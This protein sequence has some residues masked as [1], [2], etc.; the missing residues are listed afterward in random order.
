MRVDGKGGS[1]YQVADN[2]LAFSSSG[3]SGADDSSS[4]GGSSRLATGVLGSGGVL[5]D[6]SSRDSGLITTARTTGVVAASAG[7]LLEG[8]VKLGRHCVCLCLERE[9]CE[10]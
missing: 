10:L 2:N 1:T 9:M 3:K 5:G 4:G 8:L 7:N 6:T